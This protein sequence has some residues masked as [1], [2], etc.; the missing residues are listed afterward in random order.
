MATKWDKKRS[1][2]YCLAVEQSNYP[3]NT[4]AALAPL[5]RKCKSVI[6]IGAGCGALTIP[7][8]EK[9]RKVTAIEPS[10]WMYDLLVKRA[11]KAGI[12]NITAFNTGW[13]G[14]RMQGGIHEKL[15][16]HDMVICANLPYT[17]VCN[18]RFLR[19]IT[20]ISG[21]FIV[22]IQNAGGWNR[23]YYRQLYP[24][25]LKKKYTDE[26]D[27]INTYNFLH[28]QGILA[29]VKIFEY[30]LDQPFKDFDEALD[31]WK[32]RMGIKFTPEKER[33]LVRFLK[34]KLITLGKTGSLKAVFGP[35]QTALTWWKP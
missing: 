20:G 19:Y 35:R 7:I 31:F 9:V 17:M 26:C 21:N 13:K 24:M 23:F 8:A 34:K 5:L 28:K 10:K 2:W 4:T 1:E 22:Y 16:T 32:H 15:K 11:G 3:K 29:N 33:L 18:M 25:L 6:D 27:Y 30:S 14:N 12:R